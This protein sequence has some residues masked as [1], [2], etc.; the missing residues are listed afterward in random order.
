V[1][2][3]RGINPVRAESI[4]DLFLFGVGVGFIVELDLWFGLGMKGTVF[5]ARLLLNF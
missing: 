1:V 3:E 4:R 5:L 2:L